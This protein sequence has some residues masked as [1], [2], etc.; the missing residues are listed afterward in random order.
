MGS[1]NRRNMPCHCGSGKKYKNCCYD[2][3]TGTR[4]RGVTFT[5]K[6]DALLTG[7]EIGPNG[8]VRI[9]SGEKEVQL[10][11][12]KAVEW[13]E[14]GKGYKFKSQI[15]LA[16]GSLYFDPEAALADSQALHFQPVIAGRHS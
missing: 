3:D 13:R 6:E 5:L 8:E 14:T 1:G 15:D 7:I 2:N 16:E 12:A 4:I 11:N 10:E 9:L